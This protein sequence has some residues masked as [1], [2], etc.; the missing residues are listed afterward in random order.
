LLTPVIAWRGTNAK[1][2]DVLASPVAVAV[3]RAVHALATF[4]TKT[5]EALTLAR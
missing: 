1:L 5:L 3:A 4:A 2:L